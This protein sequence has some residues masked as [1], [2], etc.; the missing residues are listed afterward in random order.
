MQT[1]RELFRVRREL[2][3]GFAR[4]PGFIWYDHGP[5]CLRRSVRLCD[6][7]AFVRP[8]GPSCFGQ[9][10]SGSAHRRHRG[11]IGKGL[12][13]S[14]DAAIVRFGLGIGDDKPVLFDLAAGSLGTRPARPQALR[15]PAST[16]L[17]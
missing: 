6:G 13:I 14:D 4:R 11:K 1:S 17:R 3:P 16:A 9:G 8:G 7:R 5:P 12:E 10:S 2:I 15:L